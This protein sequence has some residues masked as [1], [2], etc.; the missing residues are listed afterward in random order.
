[1]LTAGEQCIT[2]LTR[3]RQLGDVSTKD[4]CACFFSFQQWP[5][6]VFCW[7]PK[8]EEHVLHNH[9]AGSLLHWAAS[10]SHAQR[11]EPRASWHTAD[12]ASRFK[13][14]TVL[15]SVPSHFLFRSPSLTAGL[16][17]STICC[18]CLWLSPDTVTPDC[19]R[20]P[21]SPAQASSQRHIVSGPWRLCSTL[22]D[23]RSQILSSSSRWWFC[24]AVRPQANQLTAHGESP[25]AACLS[26]PFLEKKNLL[27]V[28]LGPDLSVTE[29]RTDDITCSLCED[30]MN[31]SPPCLTATWLDLPINIHFHAN[32]GRLRSIP[33]RE[34][35][36]RWIL[37]IDLVSKSSARWYL[38]FSRCHNHWI[39]LWAFCWTQ[40]F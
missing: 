30:R 27:G 21:A 33:K 16:E 9:F 11:L 31:E 35:A 22:P 25:F 7:R 12:G 4:V 39:V 17:V 40:L 3:Y 2:D 18:T 29:H 37:T 34:W 15:F 36:I 20:R 19:R 23:L 38:L 10:M 13:W 1:M 32:R 26:F 5:L 14:P 6:R 8:L 28:F 24:S